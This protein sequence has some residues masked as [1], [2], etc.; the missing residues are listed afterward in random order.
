MHIGE[1][2]GAAFGRVG[3][4]LWKFTDVWNFVLCHKDKSIHVK[5]EIGGS[6]G[7]LPYFDQ[8]LISTTFFNLTL[9][10]GY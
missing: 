6:L 9:L 2:G 3:K 8:S 1:G 7:K 5:D 4:I 10:L